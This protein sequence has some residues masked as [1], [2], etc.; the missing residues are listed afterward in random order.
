[1]KNGRKEK[2]QEDEEAK[3]DR[4]RISITQRSG[5]DGTDEN[6]GSSEGNCGTRK[7]PGAIFRRY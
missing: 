5:T 2:N 7:G 3:E 6:D 1:M 4:G